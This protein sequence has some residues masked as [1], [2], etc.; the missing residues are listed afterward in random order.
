MLKAY[1]F[2]L[3]GTLHD[4][5]LSE[6]EALEKLFR[7]DIVLDPM[8]SFSSF[9]RAW[10]NASEEYLSSSPKGKL[11]FDEKHA[12]RVMDTL[13]QFGSEVTAEQARAIFQKYGAH[14]EKSWRPYADAVPAL[15]AL[16]GRFKLGIIT[17]GDSAMQ[18]GKIKACGVTPFADSI[19]VSGEAGVTKPDPAIF[20]LSRRALG[21]E[22]G[23]L[24][25]VGDRLETDALAAK[26]AGWQGIWINRKH[27]PGNE[28][29]PGI[30]VI[31]S[32]LELRDEA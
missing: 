4:Q 21:L 2:D 13:S 19:I 29:T 1:I 31:N 30:R 18:R 8:P 32:L 5:E 28:I 9:L 7:E 23:E 15:E 27:M 24:A 14:Y 20:E 11:S 25:Y 3:D 6:R 10:R 17:N 26:A 16:K 12:G 22:P